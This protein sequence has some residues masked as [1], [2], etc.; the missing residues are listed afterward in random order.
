MLNKYIFTSIYLEIEKNMFCLV[1]FNRVLRLFEWSTTRVI[2]ANYRHIFTKKHILLMSLIIM[3]KLYSND[4][5]F[6]VAI[7]WV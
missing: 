7:N 5:P 3:F 2:S 1:N 6:H 4:V